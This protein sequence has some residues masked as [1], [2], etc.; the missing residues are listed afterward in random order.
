MKWKTDW[1]A[2]EREKMKAV[3]QGLANESRTVVSV[4]TAGLRIYSPN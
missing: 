1:R 3:L 4:W 2:E